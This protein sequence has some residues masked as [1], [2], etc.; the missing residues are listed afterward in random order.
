MTRA[1]DLDDPIA[2]AYIDWCIRERIPENTIRRRRSV[3]RAVGNPGA[4]TREQIESWWATRRHLKDSTRANDLAILRSFYR[5]TQTWEWRTD[6]PTLR[7]PAPR[8]ETGAPQPVSGRDLVRLR[9][10][11]EALPPKTGKPLLRAVLLGAGAGLRR[12]E[13]ANLDWP[14]ID[15]DTRQARVRGKGRKIRYVSFSTKLIAELAPDTG[16]N[17]ITGKPAGWTPD[18]LGRKVN[19]AMRDAG[20][21]GTY[22]KLRH[23]YG[24]LAYQ[25]L[26]DPRA[27]ADMMGHTSVA[28]T[29]KYYAAAADDAGRAIA[30]AVTEDW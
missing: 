15:P 18:T 30:D 19:A 20:I 29:M 8:L 3:L 25:R 22:H 24:S 17:V 4:A 10:H 26:K 27:L 12:E 11:L 23:H 9:I 6:D 28:T 13:A 16:G 5:W 21:D 2:A 7:L 14:D 1:L